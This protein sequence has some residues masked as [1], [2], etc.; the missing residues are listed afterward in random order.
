MTMH[1]S[2]TL[3][4]G[5]GDLL[6]GDSIAKAG[7]AMV[8][9]IV[10]AESGLLVGFFLPGDSMLF[11]LGM[12]IS[13]DE[14]STSLPL[15]VILIAV[16]AVAGDQVGYLFGR[17]V[18]PALFARPNSR[19]F[20]QEYVEQA[21]EFFAKNGP[22]SIVLARFVPVVRTFTPIIAGV[23]RMNYR[24]FSL[25]NIVGAVVW[26]CG[27][28]LLGYFLGSI[29]FV[30]NNIEAMLVLV[31]LVSVAPIAIEYLRKRR[32]RRSGS[33]P[34]GTQ[35]PPVDQELGGRSATGGDGT[36]PEHNVERHTAD[37]SDGF[38]GPGSMVDYEQA[39]ADPSATMQLRRSGGRHSSDP[40]RQTARD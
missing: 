15:A 3:A 26:G 13:R 38:G 30:H 20:K 2:T 22:R 27:V 29:D 21:N 39:G 36:L 1:E 28:T 6:S 19:F 14:V 12:L 23:S 17:K 18:G 31:V 9:L 11:T 37:G 24:V 34:A 7:L 33:G 40:R 10:F 4:L 32:H 5:A 16:A 8:L 25:Y 35:Q